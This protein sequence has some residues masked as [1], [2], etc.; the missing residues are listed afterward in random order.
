[1]GDMKTGLFLCTHA[2]YSM[3]LFGSTD[4]QSLVAYMETREALQGLLNE[5]VFRSDN[6]NRIAYANRAF[7][8]LFGYNRLPERPLELSAIYASERDAHYI[9]D[10]LTA[11]GLIAEQR[12]L[13]KR[14]DGS[15]FWGSFSC[16]KSKRNNTLVVEGVIHDVSHR[17]AQESEAK[18]RAAVLEKTKLE[19]DRFIYSAS[20][21]IRSPISTVQG[22]IGLMK[23]ELHDSKSMELIQMMESS[24]KKLDIIVREL[25]TFAKNSR[26]EIKLTQIDTKE[27]FADMLGLLRDE[28]GSYSSVKIK[29]AILEEHTFCSDIERVKMCVYPVIKNALDFLD[30]SKPNRMVDIQCKVTP[31]KAVIE[32]FD[33]GIG[34]SPVN[35]NSVFEM[36]YKGTNLSKG[37][38]LGLYIAREA[39]IKL[40]GTIS[41][42]SKYAIGTSVKIEIP[43]KYLINGKSR[44][45][46]QNFLKNDA[47]V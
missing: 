27:L 32:I 36:F 7:L 34:I 29:S 46:S 33:N 11:G 14:L 26:Q 24:I 1:M 40:G 42:N 38:G 8:N 39:A 2:Y 9:N 45:T 23:L 31:L 13:F 12:F 20:H 28:H 43:N 18:E 6:Q 30:M 3:N 35:L 17:I 25:G 37:S 15:N 4:E 47:A 5:G 44:V 21:D 41:I 19:L 10:K 22:L 16:Q